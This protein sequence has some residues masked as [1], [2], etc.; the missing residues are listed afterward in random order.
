MRWWLA[1]FLFA[2]VPVDAAQTFVQEQSCAGND[3]TCTFDGATTSGNAVIVGAWVDSVTETITISGNTFALTATAASPV[4]TTDT[5]LYIWA[6][7][8]DGDASYLFTSSGAGVVAVKMV[9]FT[10]TQATRDAEGSA[11]GS[12]SVPTHNVVTTV[13]NTVMFSLARAGAN[14]TWTAGSGYTLIETAG[15]TTFAGEYQVFT[16]SGSK[17]V[18]YSLSSSTAWDVIS[19]AFPSSEAAPA[20]PPRGSLGL[21]GAGR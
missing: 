2:A 14:R 3:V 17:T 12:S 15:S 11:E 5:R 9:E 20:G 7:I 6:G 16:S 21:M 10:N 8:A 4:T 1:L 13:T 19:A 18:S